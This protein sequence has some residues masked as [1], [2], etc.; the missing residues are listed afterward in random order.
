M[1]REIFWRCQ[2]SEA[3]KTFF[4]TLLM[5]MK[6]S[7]SVSENDHDIPGGHLPCT[8]TAPTSIATPTPMFTGPAIADC[9]GTW[10]FSCLSSPLDIQRIANKRPNN[11]DQRI[12]SHQK[13]SQCL[14]RFQQTVGKAQF[15][16]HTVRNANTP[17]ARKVYSG[18]DEAH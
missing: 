3:Q 8:A 17:V 16:V 10:Y 12:H 18:S 4:K 7:R 5:S 11:T 1:D 9:C 14:V 6:Q 13:V 15:T 2:L